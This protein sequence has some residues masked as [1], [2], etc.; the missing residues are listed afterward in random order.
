MPVNSNQATLR[1]IDGLVYRCFLPDLTGFTSIYCARPNY[2]HYLTNADPTKCVLK[3]SINPATADCRLQGTATS[4]SSTA[5][6]IW[7][8]ERDSNP[9][10]CYGLHAFQACPLANSD[11]SPFYLLLRKN[12]CNNDLHSSDSMPGKT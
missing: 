12:D 1:H 7:R 4:P 9:R 3:L 10:A 6:L 11:I 8:R 5:Y 2:Q